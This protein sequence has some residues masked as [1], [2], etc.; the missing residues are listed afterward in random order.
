MKAVKTGLSFSCRSSKHSVP[1]SCLQCA[2]APKSIKPP[3]QNSLPRS[4]TTPGRC[5]NAP[6]SRVCETRPLKALRRPPGYP[7]TGPRSRGAS[8]RGGAP[9]ADLGSQH[10]PP[11]RPPSLRLIKREK[12][13]SAFKPRD[14][15]FR[16]T[17]QLVALP[18]RPSPPPLI[19][20]PGEQCG[21]RCEDSEEERRWL[22][23]WGGGRLGEA[24]VL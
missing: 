24:V 17:T 5:H 20:S 9:L 21:R 8:V 6:Y 12:K 4:P 18:P 7:G 15:G 1:S 23:F 16:H 13:T 14:P 2:V 22:G 11:A 10:R 3:P 19:G